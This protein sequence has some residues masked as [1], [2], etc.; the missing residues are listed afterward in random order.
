MRYIVNIR[1]GGHN[2][3][4]PEWRPPDKSSPYFT[5]RTTNSSV[6]ETHGYLVL[7]VDDEPF[8]RELRRE[9]L[10]RV[11]YRVIEAGNGR[12]AIEAA[13]RERPRL[14]L[15]NYLMPELDGIRA[16]KFIH[17]SPELRRIPIIMNSACRELE[18]KWQALQAG[19]VD[20]IEEPGG[21]NEL[22]FKVSRH[23]LVG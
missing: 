12:E 4:R 22:L 2:R 18:A 15:M 5:D 6:T 7:I 8:I 17:Q 23:I 16:S 1:D 3:T 13:I 9:V 14:I 19:C 10:E 11:G 20:Y 21:I